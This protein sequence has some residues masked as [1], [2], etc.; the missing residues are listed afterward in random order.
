MNKLGLAA[1]S[2]SS[3]TI[4][5]G[6]NRRTYASAEKIFSLGPEHKVILLHSGTTEFLDH[7][8]EV[9]ITEWKKTLNR[10]LQKLDDYVD[11]LINWI[12]HRQDLFSEELQ[13]EFLKDLAREY[14]LD[15]RSY[16]MTALE[17]QKVPSNEWNSEEAFRI[18]NEV[19]EN[20]ITWLDGRADLIGLNSNWCDSRY[21]TFK[22]VFSEVIE[23]VFDDVP[24]NHISEKHYEAICRR[25]MFKSFPS[26]QFDARIVFAGYGEQDIY[27]I[28]SYIDLQGAIADR[29]RYQRAS[30]EI[31]P[32]MGSNLRTHGQDEA[33]HT[34]LRAYD[35]SFL[36]VAIS[37]LREFSATLENDVIA[38]LTQG[39][40]EEVE[41]VVQE[42][43][44]EQIERLRSSFEEKSE[45]DWVD[46]FTSTLAGLPIT[47][48]A[49]MA[50]SLIELQILRQSSQ[51]VQD[52]VGGPV[53]VAVVT[54]ERGVEW[55]RH[56]TVEDLWR[57]I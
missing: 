2:D 57:S 3:V 51:A 6:N 17:D 40:N 25:L 53:D 14:L 37:N 8:F 38:S 45:R 32:S 42:R 13:S 23:Y 4:S 56:K 31:T 54:R 26:Y 24:R 48:L 5:R 21:N 36:Q 46:P 34:F 50:E 11:S 35:R 16:I 49:K 39:E 52:T 7:P 28:Q 30:E 41:G 33:I 55:F 20:D 19:L 27:P 9:L 47:S 44:T 12:S 10:P 29:P 43:L 18:A 22:D 1:A 15:I